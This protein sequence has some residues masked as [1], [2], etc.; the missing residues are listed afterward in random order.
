MH[1]PLLRSSASVACPPTSHPVSPTVYRSDTTMAR[2]PL[3]AHLSCE[4][5]KTRVYTHLRRSVAFTARNYIYRQHTFFNQVLLLSAK[6]SQRLPEYSN[7]G[8]ATKRVR[9]DHPYS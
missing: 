9:A 2:G 6:A 8:S 3:I 7:R 4:V 1:Q 5:R